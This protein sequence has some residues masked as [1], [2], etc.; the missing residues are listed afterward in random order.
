MRKILLALVA[1]VSSSAAAITLAAPAG[2]ITGDFVKD[3]EHPYVGLIAFYDSAGGFTHRC[4]GSLLS[5]TVVLTAGHCTDANTG[6]VRAVMWFQ[7]DAGA[8]FD[9]ETGAPA[10]SGY[11][12]HRHVEYRCQ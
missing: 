2:A 10:K 3:T 11:P 4:S 12:A 7:Q 5:P 9:A 8:D 1:I 6:A